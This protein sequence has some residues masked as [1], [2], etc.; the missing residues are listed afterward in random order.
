MIN[1]VIEIVLQ[2]LFAAGFGS[3]SL[4]GIALVSLIWDLRSGT[5][6]QE[7]K[8]TVIFIEAHVVILLVC[9]LL[10]RILRG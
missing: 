7:V 5:C 4:L 10:D 6:W 1:M 8:G 2:L 9:Y 3:A